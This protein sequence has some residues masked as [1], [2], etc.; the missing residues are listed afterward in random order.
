[1]KSK[2]LSLSAMILGLLG[3]SLANPTEGSAQIVNCWLSLSPPN[4]TGNIII[5][6]PWND[7]PYD[8][9]AADN[10]GVFQDQVLAAPPEIPLGHYVGWCIDTIDSITSYATT[11]NGVVYYSSCDPNLDTELPQIYPGS[12]YVSPM[13]WQEINYLLNHK[14]GAYFWDIQNAIWN[15]IGGPPP[16]FPSYYP[17]LTPGVVSALLADANANAGVWQPECGDVLAVVVGIPV[18]PQNQ[19]TNQL[20]IIEVPYP[21]VPSIGIT[22]QVACLQPGDTCG[23]FGSTA[24]GYKGAS[25]PAFCY[26][27]TITNNGTMTLSNFTVLDNLL[28]NITTNFFPNTNAILAPNGAATVYFK[29]PVAVTTTNIAM[30]AGEAVPTLAVVAATNSAIAQ[31]D[32][33]GIA[34]NLTLSS[35]CDQGGN[36][37]G[38][39]LPGCGQPCAVTFTIT[40]TNTGAAN[41]TAVTIS[42]AALAALQGCTLPAPFNL[43]AGASQT[44]TCSPTVSCP[45]GAETVNVSVTGQVASDTTH[46]GVYDVNGQPISVTSACS[47]TIVCG[48]ELGGISGL[49]VLYCS[50]TSQGLL[51]TETGIPG[52]TVSLLNSSSAVIATTTTSAGGAYSFPNLAPGTYTVQVTP[53]ANCTETFPLGTT[54]N[55][56][57]VVLLGCEQ[58]T[59][60]F[61]YQYTVPPTILTAPPGG[62]LGCNPATLPTDASIKAL[63]TASS[64][65]GPVTV[66][67]THVDGGTACAPTR[68]F[69]I[70]ASDSCNTSAPTTVVYTWT[71]NT[72][73]PVI[74]YCPPNVTILTSNCV[75]TTHCTFSKSDWCSNPVGTSWWNNWGVNYGGGNNWSWNNGWVSC[76]GNNP[77]AILNSCF[78]TV[79]NGGYCQIGLPNG[80][81]C[82]KFNSTSAIQACLANSGPAGY[83]NGNGVNPNNC[84]AG[85]FCAE[86]LALQLNCDYGDAGYKIAFGAPCSGYVLNDPTSPCNGKCVRDILNIANCVLGGGKPSNPGCTVTYLCGL[87]DNLNKSFEGCQTS[88]WCQSH[89]TP[90]STFIPPPP[91]QT[92]TA[93]ATDTCDANPTVTYG[94]VVTAGGCSGGHIVTRTWTATDSCSN[95]TTCTQVI[96][97][98]TCPALT[99]GCASGSGQVGVSYSSTL[100]A[101]GGAPPY[102]FSITSGSLPPVLMLNKTTGAI[103][104]TPTTA[105]TYTFTAQVTD[106]MGQTAVSSG[107]GCVICIAPPCA[108]SISGSV[109]RDCNGDGNLSGDTGIPGVTVTLKNGGTTVATTITDANGAYTF[110]GLSADTYVVVVTP[111]ANSKLT[112]PSP[113]CNHQTTITLGKCQNV[114]GVNFGYTGTQCAVVVKLSCQPSA[115]CGNTI[116]YTCTVQNT[117]NVCFNGGVKVSSQHCGWQVNC[118]T[119]VQPGQ[120]CVLTTKYV[121]QY[122]DYPQLNCDATATGY[123]NNGNYATCQ[124]SCNTQIS[125]Y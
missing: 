73:G 26:Q 49:V 67:V 100:V 47:G 65:L 10:P 46:C 124:T 23:T 20:T 27:I 25:D 85:V 102:M 66:T 75:V 84:S 55:Q 22:K 13:V 114:T 54:G 101:A 5:S 50:P 62:N 1:M 12:V 88:G 4:D 29:M 53:P 11:Y 9:A 14:H 21:C 35:T 43:A 77:G 112:Y 60:N 78:G 115:K 95:S 81:Y 80:G 106:S 122:G 48:P 61:G 79:Y 70:T 72:T 7:P 103:T 42:S 119:P 123:P 19:V 16:V 69:T 83:L 32:T 117:G 31:V 28:G 104:G 89:L 30:V 38:V 33:A 41:L 87:C 74:T 125:R 36:P 111:P 113:Y 108:G 92:G 18:T 121:V 15:L 90:P 40:V 120:V 58:A 94:D 45:G 59:A 63:V 57:Q 99:L 76:N 93:T 39:Q 37:T 96:T 8:Y 109:I 97:V 116:T 17:T 52:V 86:V 107:G 51:G 68:T 98:S 3:F 91:S 110:G 34:C 6:A 118:P 105:G 82:L 64:G 71:E 44:F 56:T 2:F 24:E